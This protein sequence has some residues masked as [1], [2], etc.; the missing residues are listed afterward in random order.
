[1]QRQGA[2]SH[3]SV[4]DIIVQ[5]LMTEYLFCKYW[6]PSSPGTC[7]P[8]S[9]ADTE[10]MANV[11]HQVVPQQ[12]EAVQDVAGHQHQPNRY[13]PE[14]ARVSDDYDDEVDVKLEPYGLLH[15]CIM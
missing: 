4:D 8:A 9:P 10:T 6:F 1:M 3:K 12:V 14:N 13:G 7:R 15:Q 5:F 11:Q 2:R